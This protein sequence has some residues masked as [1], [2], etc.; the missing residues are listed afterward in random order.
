MFAYVFRMRS[1]SLSKAIDEGKWKKRLFSRL[2]KPWLTHFHSSFFQMWMAAVIEKEREV[3]PLGR[4][5]YESRPSHD[6]FAWRCHNGIPI[7]QC[8]DLRVAVF[9]MESAAR[10]HAPVFIFIHRAS[11][12]FSRRFSRIISLS[13]SMKTVNT[14]T[15]W[16]YNTTRL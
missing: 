10:T 12:F 13:F 16:R 5:V 15:N 7:Q 6:T 2:E 11:W 4:G 8:I 9:R 3:D 1:S 14:L